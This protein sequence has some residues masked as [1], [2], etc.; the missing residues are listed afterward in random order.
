MKP[1]KFVSAGEPVTALIALTEMFSGK[2]AVQIV[3]PHTS[4]GE[5]SVGDDVGLVVFSSGSTGTPKRIELSVE[6]LK[7]S[8]DLSAERLGGHGQW[9]S[10]LPLEYIAGIQVLVRSVVAE[11]QPIIM[12]TAVGFT[13]E[14]F[15]RAAGMM[16]G[17]LR[18]VSLVPTQFDLLLAAAKHDDHVLRMLQ[19]FNAILLGGQMP[20]LES[21][22]LAISLNLNIVVT[23]G[24]A[25]TAG[26]V[27]YN[28]IPLDGVTVFLNEDGLISIDSPTLANNCA[29][30]F[31]TSDIG[32]WLNGQLVIAGRADR[33]I[34][35]GGVKVSLER[36]E[37]WALAQPGVIEA[38]AV[39]VDHEK[40][41]QSFTCFLVMENGFEFDSTHAAANLGLAAKSGSW[42]Q[43]ETIPKLASGKPDLQ[44]LSVLA[45]QFGEDL[46]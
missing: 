4:H 40:F 22:E 9:L 17:E 29:R 10:C 39:E 33:V 14:G 18:Y 23:Y 8:A 2:L 16:T 20:R 15:S 6:A 43:S 5:E 34:N 36:V 30:P 37:A 31:Q 19:R 12:N 41:G 42:K 28:G 32:A 11:T 45:N 38:A 26:G 46:G 13:S 44:F 1:I 7:T 21:L 27:V 3:E 35:S 25:E 24:M